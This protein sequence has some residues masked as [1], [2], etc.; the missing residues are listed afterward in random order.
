[1]QFWA[2]LRRDLFGHPGR[3]GLVEPQVVPPGHRYKVA[4]PHVGQLMGLCFDKVAFEIHRF[5][6]RLGQHAQGV[7]SDQTWVFHRT[8]TQREGQ[9]HDV[10][11]FIRVGHAK[12][13][14]Q[15]GK[16]TGRHAGGKRRFFGTA[17]WGDKAHGRP[18]DHATIQNVKWAHAK[19]QQVARQWL[20]GLE[21]D[22]LLTFLKRHF[23]RHGRA[24]DRSHG[25][26]NGQRQGPWHLPAWLVKSREGL[27][28]ADRFKLREGIP[29]AALFLTE[30]ALAVLVFDAAGKGNVELAFAFRKGLRK[31]Q[32]QHIGCT[33]FCTGSEGLATHRQ[34]GRTHGDVHRM[35]AYRL[36]GLFDIN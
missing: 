7:E 31:I 5:L 11:L 21:F 12:V 34:H 33:L 23:T 25:L 28:G 8:K 32:I 35:H 24:G 22:P 26:G 14:F 16:D 36:A 17:A 30:Q 4:K 9:D 15:L 1:M 18:A 3:E 29:F 27:A 19:G 20:G 6:T 10:Q 2:H 13:S